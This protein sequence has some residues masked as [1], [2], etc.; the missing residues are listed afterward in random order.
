MSISQDQLF[1]SVLS[2]PA[3]VRADLALEL[4]QSLNAPG[5]E[6]GSSEFEREL[7]ERVAAHQRGEAQSFSLEQTRAIIRRRLSQERGK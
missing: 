5:E 1:E 3:T 4:L 2:L 7:H 6:I